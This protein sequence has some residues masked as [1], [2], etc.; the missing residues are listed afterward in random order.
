MN[1]MKIAILG[2][3]IEGRSAQKF[4]KKKY[5]SSKIEIRD[6]KRQSGRYL[7]DLGRFDIIVRSPGIKYLLPE[8]QNAKK[9]GVKI[10]SPTRLFFKYARGSIIGITGTKGKGTTASMLYSILKCAGK[11]V[12]LAGNIGVPV[13]DILPNLSK[14]SIVIVELSSFQLQD[15]DI[16]PHVAVILDIAPD[17]LDYHE[18]MKEYV[19]AKSHIA[20]HQKKNDVVVYIKNNL[21]ARNIAKK[22]KGTKISVDVVREGEKLSNDVIIPGVHNMHN[23][24]VAAAVARV[25]KI[26]ENTIREGLRGFRGLP[27]HLEI[28]GQ[29]NGV[30]Y[31]NDSASTNPVS[32]IA[33]LAA[34]SGPKVLIA[35]GA[36]KNFGYG[37]LK[38]VIKNTN[39]YRVVLYGANRLKISSAI[40]R[41][42]RIVMAK[43]LPEAVT[44]AKN[45]AQKGDSVIF[46]PASASFD[47]FTDAK[48]RG[49]MFNR[50]VRFTR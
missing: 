21:F 30:T 12:R 18:S 4:L 13:L 34:I 29:Y 27:Y 38:N 41:S 39:T 11:D 33:A 17:H 3:G 46:S 2:Y 15:M 47:L 8:I 49:H 24:A 42:A 14:K 31:Y 22:S 45:I 44:L 23:A 50:L 6:K 37:I 5:S 26:D 9:N 48:E 19:T 1:Y 43:K 16:S 40:G 28:V 35:G 36:D 7:E 32:T 20:L 25:F 10:T